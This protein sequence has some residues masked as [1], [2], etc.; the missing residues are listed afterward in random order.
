MPYDLGSAPIPNYPV[1]FL[2]R[3][4]SS[5]H[6]QDLNDK[7][8]VELLMGAVFGIAALVG[9][10]TGGDHSCWVDEGL[11]GGGGTNYIGGTWWG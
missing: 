9:S 1:R 8:C 6:I 3:R 7:V 11:G 2:P 4:A 5:V 10:P